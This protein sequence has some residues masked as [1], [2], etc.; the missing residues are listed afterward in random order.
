MLWLR[1]RL[2][3]GRVRMLDQV[4]ASI[5]VLRDDDSLS[6]AY[7]PIE[8]AWERFAPRALSSAGDEE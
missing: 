6:F 2:R 4:D 7:L 8:P 1:L 5:A 3:Q